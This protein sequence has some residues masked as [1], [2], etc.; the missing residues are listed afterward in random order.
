MAE[1]SKMINGFL[2]DLAVLN[3]KVHN[4]HWN[5]VGMEFVA[6]HKMTEK[7]YEKLAEQFDEVAEIMKMKNM[8]PVAKMADYLEYSVI[9]E[10]ES[11]PYQ[12]DEVINILIKDI[13]LLIERAKKVRDDAAKD[14]DFLVANMADEYLKYYAKK[15]WMIN[16]MLEEE[17]KEFE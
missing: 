9:E 10:V 12:A 4:L 5:V 16:A 2:A 11:K 14:D 3:V 15:S 13:N 8:M 7:L 1:R 6:V 17:P